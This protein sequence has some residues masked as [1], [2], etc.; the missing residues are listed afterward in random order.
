MPI[1]PQEFA[2]MLGA[3]IVGEVPDVGGGPFGM[4]QLAHILHERLTAA[5]TPFEMKAAR[6]GKLQPEGQK[7]GQP[8]K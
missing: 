8:R 4:A 2:D 7:V 6:S 5:S 3:E 1:T